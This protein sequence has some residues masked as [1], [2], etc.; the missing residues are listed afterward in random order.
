MP[1]DS[2][3]A[4]ADA[5]ARRLGVWDARLVAVPPIPAFQYAPR[6]PPPRPVVPLLPPPPRAS[7]KKQL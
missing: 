2:G 6:P 7:S 3:A 4:A 5:L 1:N